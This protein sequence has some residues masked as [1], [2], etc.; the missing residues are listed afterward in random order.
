VI[1]ALGGGWADSYITKP[2]I[3]AALGDFLR[4]QIKRAGERAEQVNLDELVAGFRA[5]RGASTKAATA[6]SRHASQVPRPTRA[7]PRRDNPRPHRHARCTTNPSSR[8]RC[9][10]PGCAVAGRGGRS[11]VHQHVNRAMQQLPG[12]DLAPR[13]LADD[14][15]VEI[16]H[17]EKLVRVGRITSISTGTVPGPFSFAGHRPRRRRRR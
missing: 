9:P 3:P 5:K 1:K 13:R 17:I 8:E 15:V 11:V 12:M 16:D 2:D 10:C 4:V 6:G 14:P 7:A